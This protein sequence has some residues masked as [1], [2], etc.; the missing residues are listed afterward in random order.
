VASR[1]PSDTSS[2]TT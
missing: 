2:Y 1:R